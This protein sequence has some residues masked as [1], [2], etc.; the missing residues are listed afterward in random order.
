MINK[1][2]LLLFKLFLI[3][4]PV[5]ILGQD[6]VLKNIQQKIA[7]SKQQGIHEKLYA[8]TDKDFYLAGEIIWFKLYSVDASTNQPANFSKVAYVELLERTGKPV[9]QTKI[10]LTKKGGSGSIYLPVTLNSDNYVLRAYTNWMRNEGA[11]SFF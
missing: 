3:M 11:K 5:T 10:E 7:F 1:F 6:E 4:L 2:Q 8:H 9:L